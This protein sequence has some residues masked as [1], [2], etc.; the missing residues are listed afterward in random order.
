MSRDLYTLICKIAAVFVF[1]HGLNSY[2]WIGTRWLEPL[3]ESDQTMIGYAIQNP[4]LWWQFLIVTAPSILYL[5]MAIWLWRVPNLPTDN[6]SPKSNPQPFIDSGIKL[7][8]LYLLVTK[9]PEFILGIYAEFT[10]ISDSQLAMRTIE[11]F[12]QIVLGGVFTFRTDLI[13]KLI[14]CKN[15]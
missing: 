6:L 4:N 1:L 14:R 5:I 2:L 11:A 7:I 10:D 15:E 8:G 9:I 12:V 13:I 3:Y